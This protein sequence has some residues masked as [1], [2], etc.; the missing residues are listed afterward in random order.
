MQVAGKLTK[1]LSITTLLSLMVFASA[2]GSRGD[3][4]AAPAAPSEP[5][6]RDAG[7]SVSDVTITMSDAMPDDRMAVVEDLDFVNKLREQVGKNLSVGSGTL[8]VSAVVTTFRLARFKVAYQPDTIAADVTVKENGQV[9]KT[10]NTSSTTVAGGSRSRRS[11]RLIRDLAK[12][13]A[14]NI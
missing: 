3:R 11:T 10:F 14:A 6:L 5:T 1:L 13:I 9:V 8:S 12:K 4:E 7:K 2:C